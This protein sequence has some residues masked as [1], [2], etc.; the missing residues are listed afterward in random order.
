VLTHRKHFPP[1]A[2]KSF[3]TNGRFSYSAAK[4]SLHTSLERNIYSFRACGN[5]AP[6]RSA[7]V[8]LPVFSGALRIPSSAIPLGGGNLMKARTKLISRMGW[9]LTLAAILF[10]AIPAAAQQ[11]ARIPT[12]IFGGFMFIFLIFCLVMY[13]Y[14]A[15]ALQTIA[16]K[17]DTENAW[18]AWIPIANIVLMLNIAKK[19]IWWIIL[20]F[21]PLVSFVMYILVW[22]GIA[23]ERGKPNWWGIL[24]IIPGVNLIVPGYLAWSD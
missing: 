11:D 23:E 24:L 20:F 8:W 3:D 10:L 1:K 17:T 5:R 14:V 2:Q 13:V 4:S 15:L 21:I 12:A 19:P 16:Q 7:F 22:M 9:L 6:E 18:L